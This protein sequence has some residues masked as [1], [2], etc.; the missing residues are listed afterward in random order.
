MTRTDP[1]RGED[2]AMPT[3]PADGS[4]A[5][6]VAEVPDQVL[7]G[8]AVYS[9]RILAAYDLWVLGF[10]CSAVWHCPR[11]YMLRQYDRNVGRRHLDLGPGTGFFLDRC[12][13]P[14]DRPH[15]VLADLNEE[16]LRKTAGRLARY[17]PVM[18]RRDVLQPLELGTARFDS[19][20]MNFLLHCMPGG[21]TEKA[22]VFDHV[23]PYVAP[24]GRI[25]GATVLTH[26]VRHGRL[27][28]KAL[29]SLNEDEVMSNRND[30]LAD[31]DAAL[32]AR[33]ESYQL[34]VRGSVAMFEVSVV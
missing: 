33:F 5:G 9:R 14:V 17:R 24:G 18:Y 4:D 16:V 28:P 27:A 8:A 26:G 2:P 23:L 25:F 29:E 13:F 3:H 20:G 22:V 1:I 10:V 19:V 15:L 32:A 21:I 11:R 30:S 7:A 31:L 6:V 34:R 12:A